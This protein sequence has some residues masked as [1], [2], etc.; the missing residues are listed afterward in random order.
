MNRL[1]A[2]VRWGLT[3]LAVAAVLAGCSGVPYAPGPW[4]E[5]SPTASPAGPAPSITKPDVDFTGFL[6]T[7][8]D[9]VAQV[10]SELWFNQTTVS[11][12]LL[13]RRP[14]GWVNVRIPVSGTTTLTNTGAAPN[15]AATSVFFAY[16]VAYPADSEICRSMRIPGDGSNL[17]GGYCWQHIASATP[18]SYDRDQDQAV[19]LAP[20]QSV[21]AQF[22]TP[23]TYAPGI[24]LDTPPSDIERISAALKHPAR[25][26]ATTNE[27]TG[28]T[29]D[30]V[31]PG[32]CLGAV[33]GPTSSGTSQGREQHS[34]VGAT[35][36]V[37]CEQLPE[38]GY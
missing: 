27:I 1:L 29:Q 22:G 13:S 18:F 21:T 20:G 3:S 19:E 26:V 7:D 12:L 24:S 38:L 4:F 8:H 30:L 25:V 9:L 32:A 17:G 15:R 36:A 2:V 5:P 31:F 34:I 16:Y 23:K 6:A 33:T 14:K 11:S 37:S 28:L 35:A 10:R